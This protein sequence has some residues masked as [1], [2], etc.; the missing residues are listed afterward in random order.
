MPPI[1]CERKIMIME[2]LVKFPTDTHL[3][4]QSGKKKKG[5]STFMQ[6]QRL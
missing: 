6:A 3:A 2:I 4:Y 5:Y 1:V